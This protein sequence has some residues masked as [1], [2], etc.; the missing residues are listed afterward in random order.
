MKQTQ[1]DSVKSLQETISEKRLKVLNAIEVLNGACLF[2][3]CEF[4]K[5]PVNR[6]SGRVTELQK[7]GLIENSGLTKINKESGKKGILWQ[8]KK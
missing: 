1:I 6:V 5:W 3:I 2:E 7:D 8:R 4:L